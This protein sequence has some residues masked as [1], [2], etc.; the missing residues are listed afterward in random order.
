MASNA[1]LQHGQV[2]FLN[3]N[4]WVPNKITLQPSGRGNGLALWDAGVS[5]WTLFALPGSPIVANIDNITINGTPGQVMPAHAT[6]PQPFLVGLRHANPECTVAEMVLDSALEGPGV[7]Y[8][9]CNRDPLTGMNL[10]PSYDRVPLVGMCAR[11]TDSGI[12][13]GRARVPHIGWYNRTPRLAAANYQGGTGGVLNTYVE[14]PAVVG[15]GQEGPIQFLV[16][17]GQRTEVRGALHVNSTAPALVWARV[18]ITHPVGVDFA[19][20]AL[21][22]QGPTLMAAQVPIQFWAIGYNYM[23]LATVKLELKTSAGVASVTNGA[24][25]QLVAPCFY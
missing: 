24:Q 17:R 23:G 9:N 25:S 18:T 13:N 19:E 6:N 14:V 4:P 5:E 3:P 1:Y 7:D 20:F 16:F 2:Q 10:L 12:L 22:H 11:F 15:I 8:T 21:S